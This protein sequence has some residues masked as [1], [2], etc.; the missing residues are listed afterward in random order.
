M[1]FLKRAV[2]PA[3][4]I[5]AFAPAA[6]HA[7]VASYASGVLTLAGTSSAEQIRLGDP[8]P[9]FDDNGNSVPG[10]TVT[11]TVTAG[12]GCRSA[13]ARRATYPGDPGYSYPTV[14]CGSSVD[15]VASV[16][17]DLAGGADW[18]TWSCGCA[19][20]GVAATLAGGAGNDMLYGGPLA[21]DLH[22]GDGNDLIDG[23]TGNDS[24][25]GGDGTDEVSFRRDDTQGGYQAARTS[26]VTASLAAGT[27]SAGAEAD[28]LEG[29]ENLQGSDNADTLT[30]SAGD[31]EIDPALG[32]GSSDGGP[33]TDT[34]V[35][36]P[37]FTPDGSGVTIDMSKGTLS[38]GSTSS[39]FSN[40]ENAR[41]G[42]FSS[43]HIIGDAGPNVLDGGGWGS[44]SSWGGGS[45]CGGG[46]GWG[47]G[48]GGGGASGWGDVTGP[49]TGSAWV[50]GSGWGRESS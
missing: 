24:L 23:E 27:A 44:G 49:G 37:G 31:N 41:G 14:V 34:I 1:L 29:F 26:P 6:A 47:G 43:D 18:V 2:G 17:G 7:A 30:G 8:N 5:L 46:A 19:P 40:F 42:A 9:S 36:D 20:S 33:G 35:S 4:I 22:G 12:S 16:H 50:S 28:T 38:T 39:T 48:S 3:V 11:G 10:F 21:D 32:G 15:D 25:H 45:G 13:K